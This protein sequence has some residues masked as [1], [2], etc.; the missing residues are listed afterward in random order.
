LWLAKRKP[1]WRGPTMSMPQRLV[2][3]QPPALSGKTRPTSAR[4]KVS[5]RFR[6][7]QARARA[8]HPRY[9]FARKTPGPSRRGR[10]RVRTDPPP[11]FFP[12]LLRGL[13]ACQFF[14]LA[15][16]PNIVYYSNLVYNR[17]LPF[18]CNGSFAKF[19]NE[20]VAAVR[21]WLGASVVFLPSSSAALHAIG[22]ELDEGELRPNAQ[23]F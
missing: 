8:K 4:H 9:V 22:P 18:P 2:G 6:S 1:T 23:T 12:G 21:T 11:G 3:W 5:V 13:A 16:V 10:H 19:A 20:A 7:A 17:Y 15:T 14:G